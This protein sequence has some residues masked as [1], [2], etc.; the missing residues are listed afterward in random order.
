MSKTSSLLRR[1]NPR[2]G[3]SAPV[4]IDADTHVDECE[5]TWGYLPAKD[6]HL[7]PRTI[8][9]SRDEMPPW[10]GPLGSARSSVGTGYESGYF[11][12]WF[13]DGQLHVRRVR[14]DSKTGTS[15]ETRELIDVPQR[16]RH[17]DELGIEVQIV[18]PTLFLSEVTRR[19]ELE[20]LLYRAYNRWISDRCIDS[21]GR[22]RWVAMIP[23]QSPTE[24]IEEIQV[25]KDLG[26]VGVFKRGIECGRRAASDPYFFPFYRAAEELNLPIC[27]HQANS[28][29]PVD[30]ILS[31]VRP[32]TEFP[33]LSAFS[34]LLADRV[35]EQFPNLRFGFIE[36]GASWVPYLLDQS[37]SKQQ[38][39]DPH[40]FVTCEVSEDL[41]YLVGNLGDRNLL[42]GSDYCHADRAS[43]R[44]AHL[45]ISTRVGLSA[46]TTQRITADNARA[47]YG[48]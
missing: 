15:R 16:V 31:P 2:S 34:V 4:Y 27:I 44:D 24:A 46:E 43:V 37:G 17:M 36:A 33:L 5:D 42:V 47:L 12:Y 48:I 29:T 3:F 28:W 18:Y 30:G 14:N 26:A 7:A 11:R 41:G 32:P 38:D 39:L 40:L 22:L 19:P 20:V 35:L 13:I 1:S 10:V 21:Q 6:R 45:Q 8:S 25:A 9:F 23:F